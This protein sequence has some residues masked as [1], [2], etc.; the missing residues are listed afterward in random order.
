MLVTVPLLFSGDLV[1][2]PVLTKSGRDFFLPLELVG[3]L[4]FALSGVPLVGASVLERIVRRR[5]SAD[6]RP[7]LRNIQ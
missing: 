4:T 5:S 1:S 3:C 6:Q 2:N 7:W